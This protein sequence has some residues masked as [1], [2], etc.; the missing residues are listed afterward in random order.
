MFGFWWKKKVDEKN[1]K[2][3]DSALEAIGIFMTLSEWEKAKKAIEEIKIKEKESLDYIIEKLE[4]KTDNEWVIEPE[5]KKLINEFK[6]KQKKLEKLQVELEEKERLYNKDI[7]NKR[8]KIRFEKIEKEVEEL[9]WAKQPDT[10]LELIKKF[11]EENTDNALV[12]KFYNNQKKKLLKIKTK[13]EKE[14]KEKIKLDAKAEAMN[15]IWETIN[16]VKDEKIKDKNIEKKSFFN[17]LKSKL[18]FYSKIQERIKRKK[19][20]DEINVL[21]E[22]NSKI[23]NEIAAKKLAS[24]HKWMT[25]EID[26]QM[27]WYDLYWKIISKDKISWDAFWFRENKDKYNFF[28]WDATWHWIRAWFIITLLNRLFIKYVDTA[29]L[30]E[31]SFEINNWLKQDL[32]SRNFVTWVF[33]EIIKDSISKINYTWMWHVPIYVYRKETWKIERIVSTWLAAGI[34]I[35]K[36]YADIKIKELNLND[37]DILL[38]YSDWIVENKNSSWEMYWFDRL[39]NALKK[40]ADTWQDT[41]K[42]YNYIINDIKIFKW[43]EDFDDDATAIII[44]RNIKK[45]IINDWS[46]Y[47]EKVK[48]KIWLNKNQIKKLQWKSIE[49]IEKELEVLKKKKETERIIKILDWYYYTW[50][51]LKLKQ[52]AIRY[53]KEWYIDKKINDYLKKAI[54]NEKSYKIKQKNTRAKNKYEILEE[55]YKK[56][57]YDTVINEIE[58]IIAADGE[59]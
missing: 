24:I 48:W 34:R 29:K 4:N 41:H 42:I 30:W 35:I 8:F 39:E 52:E 50:E 53:I 54:N 32:K 46:E 20:F 33:F 18:A 11:L 16:W 5:K 57:E 21:I 25:K 40:I 55:L 44:K 58:E 2:A 49:D 45:D 37:G 10:A 23:N 1:I 27:H 13:I 12:I 31:L 47:L 7:E 14:K 51:I 9:I 28:L 6:K 43:S 19:L 15:L 38:A 22:E 56:W 17:K 59:I 36:H 3:F 26:E